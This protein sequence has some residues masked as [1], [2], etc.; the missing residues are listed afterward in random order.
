MSRRTM[1]RNAALASKVVAPIPMVLPWQ[2]SGL[3]EPVEHPREHGAMR[4]DIRRRASAYELTVALTQRG[5][6][7]DACILVACSTGEAGALPLGEFHGWSVV[8]AD[9]ARVVVGSLYPVDD[10]FC[11]LFV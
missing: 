6:C 3:R 8:L 10:I 11:S 4:L 1:L 2:Q 5:E 7:L 9:C